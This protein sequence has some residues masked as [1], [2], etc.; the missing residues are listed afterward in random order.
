LQILALTTF[1]LIASVNKYAD[2]TE[3]QYTV[4][5]IAFYWILLTVTLTCMG[6]GKCPVFL[7]PES[8]EMFIASVINILLLAAFIATAAN[9]MGDVRAKVAA[10]FAFFLWLLNLASGYLTLRAWQDNTETEATRTTII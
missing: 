10:A 1:S 4:G 7:K 5:F 8:M 6:L 3:L 9:T 2:Y